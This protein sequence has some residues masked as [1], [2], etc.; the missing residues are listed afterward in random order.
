MLLQQDIKKR[1]MKTALEHMHSLPYIERQKIENEEIWRKKVNNMI[2]VIYNV[3]DWGIVS[4][5]DIL[6][7]CVTSVYAFTMATSTMHML[8]LIVTY[9]V[10][11]R[12]VIQK[13]QQKLGDIQTQLLKDREHA[14]LNV[15]LF[16]GQMKNHE[17]TPA[18]VM[19]LFNKVY[20]NETDLDVAWVKTSRTVSLFNAVVCMAILSSISEWTEFLMMYSVVHQLVGEIS[21]FARMLN[22]LNMNRGEWMEYINWY[23]K[24]TKP[25]TVYPQYQLPQN[26]LV[27]TDIN[28]HVGDKAKTDSDSEVGSDSVSISVSDDSSSSPEQTPFTLTGG[29]MH[30]QR[31][32]V[33]LIRGKS[34]SGKT[35]FLNAL[36][37][38]ID[39]VALA[40]HRCENF[41][42]IYAY[43]Y[44]KIRESIPGSGI[45]VRTLLRDEP[46]NNKIRRYLE[47]CQLSSK[48]S[49]VESYDTP[50]DYLSGGERMRMAIVYTMHRVDRENKDVIMLDEPEQGID[51]DETLPVLINNIIREYQGRKI[52]MVVSHMCDCI[53][54]RMPFTHLINVTKDEHANIGHVSIKPIRREL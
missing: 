8:I 22:G 48:F 42:T 34:G 43:L 3:I 4:V 20:Q 29:H 1:L 15:K 7:S 19:P 45:S 21:S 9:G 35:T 33:I 16:V 49:T 38:L 50:F 53:A 23:N 10:F 27:V 2:H 40:G 47:L 30:L 18:E 12:F 5:C 44:Q 26:G 46:D 6:V 41:H 14:D 11:Y 36:M 28:I 13:M 39:G 54:S 52:V 32:Q 17:R 24:C 37:G 31:G 51:T 25:V